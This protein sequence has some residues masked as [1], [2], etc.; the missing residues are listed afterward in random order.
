M[1]ALN[2]EAR[3]RWATL[4]VGAM[5]A[6]AAADAV[7]LA[8]AALDPGSSALRAQMWPTPESMRP[9]MLIQAYQLG[10]AFGLVVCHYRA[11]KNG[12]S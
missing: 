10:L 2:S 7:A 5:L 9:T 8:G 6:V 4:P 12:A 11:H 3:C 1:P